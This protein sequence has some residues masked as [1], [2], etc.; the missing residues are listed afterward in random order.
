MTKIQCRC[1]ATELEISADPI[2]Q[3]YCHCDDCQAVHGGAYAPE[4][5]YPADDVKVVR[6]DPMAWKL[7]R[8]PRHVPRVRH[9]SVYRSRSPTTAGCQWIPAPRGRIPARLSFAMPIRGP[10]HRR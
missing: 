9:P 8:N 10:A 1:G 3:F 6:G 4:S 5:V 7:K 2:V